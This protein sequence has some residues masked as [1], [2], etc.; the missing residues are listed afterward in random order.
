M[1]TL[2][3]LGNYSLDQLKEHI[4]GNYSVRNAE[5]GIKG[6][7]IDL[8]NFDILIAY[9]SVGSDGCDSTSFFLLQ[10]KESKKLYEVHGSHCSCHGFRGQWKPEETTIEYLK[11]DNFCFYTG[12]YDGISLKNKEAVHEYI[13]KL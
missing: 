1:L 10:N 2:C 12:G 8:E 3:D 4:I 7:D 13:N 9:E 5:D 6:S 11:S